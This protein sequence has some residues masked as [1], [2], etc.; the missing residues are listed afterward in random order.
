[1]KPK[2]VKIKGGH[3]DGKYL[4]FRPEHLA[5]SSGVGDTPE[6]AYVNWSIGKPGKLPTMPDVETE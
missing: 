1:M 4:C 6:R 2:I 3:L 5:E